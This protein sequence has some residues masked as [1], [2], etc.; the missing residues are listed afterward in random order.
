MRAFVVSSCR[1]SGFRVFLSL[2]YGAD[3]RR[4]RL[5]LPN[6]SMAYLGTVYQYKA[7]S[8]Y[9]GI[10]GPM[11]TTA[12]KQCTQ[13]KE[14]TNLQVSAQTDVSIDVSFTLIDTYTGTY[15]QSYQSFLISASSVFIHH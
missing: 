15:F 10:A 11:T 2:R 3:F 8:V 14:A 9:A 7:Q 4:S 12:V 6:D 5:V 13:P 1:K